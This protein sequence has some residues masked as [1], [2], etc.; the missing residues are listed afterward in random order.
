MNRHRAHRIFVYA[1]IYL[2]GIIIIMGLFLAPAIKERFAKT[3]TLPE[4]FPMLTKNYSAS[5]Y[6]GRVIWFDRPDVTIPVIAAKKYDM[7]Y[8]YTGDIQKGSF[9]EY[10]LGVFASKKHYV[11]YQVA[12]NETKPKLFGPFER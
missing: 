1:S 10:T 2:L 4:E 3:K 12:D 5:P 11:I 9:Q 7:H 8:V 6:E